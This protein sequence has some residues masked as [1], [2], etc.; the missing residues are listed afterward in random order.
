MAR[1]L[2]ALT[3]KE[4]PFEWTPICQ[5][6]F[7]LLKASLMTEQILTY[8]DPN[9]PY[10]LFTDASKY[11]WACVLTQEKIHLI[12]GKEVKI[13]HPIMYMSG[14]FH[15][16]HMNWACL[17]KEA[18]A[19]Y[20]SIK[21]LAYYLE[22]ADITLR[23]DHLPLKKFLVKNTLNSKVNNWAI[24]ISPFRITFEYIKGIKNTLANTMSRLIDIDPQIQQDSE[25]EGYE[26]GYY[27]FDTL[28]TM[29]ISNI[30]T[31]KKTSSE[32]EEDVL[33][34]IVRLPI[35]NEMLSNLQLQDT[36]CS[37]IITQIE[38][39][40]I[41]EG[42]TYKMQNNLLKKY[43]TDS[44][45][46]YET[47]ILPRALVAQI[48]KMAHDDLVHNGTHRTYMLLKRLYYWKGLKPSLVRHIQRCYHCQ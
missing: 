11:A 23:S 39:G 32:N 37:H 48:L 3:R 43:V 28:P 18:Y 6:S 2:N 26:F 34:D 8:P 36:F 29:E 31:A 5:E 40:N 24:E 10:V 14:L 22:D 27:T 42:Q 15:G 12:E 21:K 45:K 17:T 9:H 35:P 47:V 20:M 4:V 13:L 25:P 46:T 41:K 44:D 33:E 7:E 16:S 1:P 38:K 30:N 19:I